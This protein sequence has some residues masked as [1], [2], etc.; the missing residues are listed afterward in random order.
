[1]GGVNYTAQFNKEAA[2]IHR[3]GKNDMFVGVAFNEDGIV[4][5]ATLNEGKN[6]RKLEVKTLTLDDALKYYGQVIQNIYNQRS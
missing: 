4:E 5:H 2:F 3:S 1:V 6:E